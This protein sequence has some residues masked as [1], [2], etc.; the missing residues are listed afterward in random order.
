MV[1]NFDDMEYELIVL[2]VCFLNLLVNGV[3]GILVGYVMEILLYNLSEVIDVILFLMNY[4]K[5][6]FEDLM[7]FVKGFD[8]LIGGII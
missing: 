4:F 6:M 7:D 3:M 5:V 2:L 8:F 1:L